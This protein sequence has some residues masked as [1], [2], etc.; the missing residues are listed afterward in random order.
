MDTRR[1]L[2]DARA[3]VAASAVSHRRVEHVG[4]EGWLGV[5]SALDL[6]GRSPSSNSF[7]GVGLSVSKNPRA[8]SSIARLGGRAVTLERRDGAAGRFAL[9]GPVL[10]EA[11]S[12]WA[13][14]EGWAR[15]GSAWEVS[16]TD[17][18]DGTRRWVL[19][20]TRSLAEAEL[21]GLEDAEPDLQKVPALTATSR[22]RRRWLSYFSGAGGRGEVPF[23]A[24]ETEAGNLWVAHE[25]PELDGVWWDDRYDPASLSAPRGVI[26]PHAARRWVVTREYTL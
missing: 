11:S 1:T 8:W 4:G 9:H 6:S 23:H 10:S 13:V 5:G 21:D 7:E 26:L 20:R 14:A 19:F 25:L 15:R 17:Q 12:R 22:M 3:A 2:R 16:Y 24:V 18:E